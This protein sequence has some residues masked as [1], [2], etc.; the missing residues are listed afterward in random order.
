MYHKMFHASTEANLRLTEIAIL[1][2]QSSLRLIQAQQE[3]EEIYM[4]T[5]DDE[6][7]AAE[8]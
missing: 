1:A 7:E 4:Q 5:A 3:C 8:E 6:Q 2:Q